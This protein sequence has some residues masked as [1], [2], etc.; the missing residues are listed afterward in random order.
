MNK[1]NKSNHTGVA[2]AEIV[3]Y[4]MRL[5]ASV[6]Y[7]NITVVVSRACLPALAGAK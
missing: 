4:T 3:R 1:F 7:T 2:Y 6:P 5:A